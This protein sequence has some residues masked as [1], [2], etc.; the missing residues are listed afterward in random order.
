MGKITGAYRMIVCS[1]LVCLVL[2]AW[3]CMCVCWGCVWG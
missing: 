1:V 2:S 3:V